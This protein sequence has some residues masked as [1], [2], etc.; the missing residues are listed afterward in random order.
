MTD[1]EAQRAS[2]LAEYAPAMAKFGRA[3]RAKL[4]ARRGT[5]AGRTASEQRTG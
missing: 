5:K 4:R 3:I 1:A 2:Y